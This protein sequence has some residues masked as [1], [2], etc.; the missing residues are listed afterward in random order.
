MSEPLIVCGVD[1][2]THAT[3][4]AWAV[5]DEENEDAERRRIHFFTQWPG[6]PV[7]AVK[8]LSALLL[9][10]GDKVLAWGYE[11]RRRALSLLSG[12]AGHRYCA[13]FKMDLM[14][15]SPRA[16][17]VQRR[18]GRHKEAAS[19]RASRTGDL[20]ITASASQEGHG[21][22]DA[23]DEEGGESTDDDGEPCLV[24]P[25][26][27]AERLTIE[28][29]SRVR[30]AALA[31]ITSSGYLEE[32][33]RWCITVP[34][35]FNDQ[36][37]QTVRR[38]AAA[39]GFPNEDGRLIL[40]LE[41]EA[42]VHHARVRGAKP[43]GE[44][45]QPP[46]DLSAP[47]RRILVVDSGGGTVDLAAYVNDEAGRMVEIGLVNGGRHGSNELNH[48]FEDRLL[49]DRFGK[50]ELVKQLREEVPEAML[51]LVEAWE[52]HK[53]S[54]G[55]DTTDPVPLPIPTAVD[56]KLGAA[57]RKRLARKQRGVTDSILIT[58]K[59]MQDVFDTVVPDVLDLIDEQLAEVA[60]PSLPPDSPMPV[61]LMVGGFSNSPYLQHAFKQH[62]K[63][64]AHV[65]VPPDPSSAVLYGAVHFAYSPQT[66]ARRARYTYGVNSSTRFEPDVDPEEL[67]FV[68]SDGVARCR[69]RFAKLV[70]IGDVVDT[71]QEISDVFLPVEGDT[72][73]LIFDLYTTTQE[74]PRYVTDPGCERIGTVSVALNMRDALDD[75]QVRLY[76][77]FGET[78]IKVRAV[79]PK[80]GEE[81]ATTVHFA[82]DY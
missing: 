46:M 2:G 20:E 22:T 19:S 72:T 18:M 50:P 76:L 38:C 24:E 6:Q 67:R 79:V 28:L 82:S 73:R 75:R 12:S 53:L 27:E 11:A 57:V 10:E 39:A 31:Q 25:P 58:P 54:F 48:R 4:F 1:L 47:G 26:S 62:L 36:N 29:L 55:A 14:E 52:R 7:S 61:V 5:I 16:T 43:P 70:T 17:D 41:P 49:A 13:A 35:I 51:D 32:D 80:T 77:R 64:R 37:K 71:E 21:D 66:R 63:G 8:N 44:G 42:A 74:N 78:E 9:G 23:L 65:L 33:I 69:K 3:G 68:A 34:A 40:A 59:E 30:E 45:D 60:V 15:T 81:A 56:R